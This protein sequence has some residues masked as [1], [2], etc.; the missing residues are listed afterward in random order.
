MAKPKNNRFY[1]WLTFCILI[2]FWPLWFCHAYNNPYLLRYLH[3][4][5]SKAPGQYHVE[6]YRRVSPWDGQLLVSVTDEDGK[7]IP[8]CTIS[9]GRYDPSFP[10]L[11]WVDRHILNVYGVDVDIDAYLYP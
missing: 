10:K 1:G 11:F 8:V 9:E 5:A 7:R 4:T 6:V 2:V 3:E